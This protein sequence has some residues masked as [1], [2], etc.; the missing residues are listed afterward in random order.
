M[1]E[2]VKVEY[3]LVDEIPATQSGEYRYTISKVYH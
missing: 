3:Q 1:G 2:T